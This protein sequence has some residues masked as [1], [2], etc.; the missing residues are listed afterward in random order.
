M[1]DL[2]VV[3]STTVFDD[4][5]VKIPLFLVNLLTFTEEEQ[6]NVVLTGESSLGK[7]YNMKECLWYFREEHSETIVEISDATAR[8]LIHS[9]NAILVDDR[10]LQPIDISKAPKK[11]DA[12][13]MWERIERLEETYSIL[14][15]LVKQDSGILRPK[16]L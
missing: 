13:E 14:L 4:K 9:P 1:Q 12:K 8:A 3:L 5:N 11:G 10:T 6:R 15:R 16:K 2:D 7:T